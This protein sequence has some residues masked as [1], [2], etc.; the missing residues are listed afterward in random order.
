MRDEA[1]M[2]R[3]TDGAPP[4]RTTLAACAG[5]WLAVAA[6]AVGMASDD[7][8]HPDRWPQARST[9]LMDAATEARVTALLEQMTL[10]E[11]VGQIIQTDIGVI[12]PDELRRYPLGSVLAGADSGVHG[13]KRAPATEWLKLAREFRAVSMEARAGHVSIPV[14]FGIDA[15]HGHND[16][17]G[18]VLFPH[19]IGL[20]AAHDPDLVR[21]IGAATAEEVAAT[22]IDWTFAPTLATPRDVRWGRTYEGY[23]QDPATVRS[24]AA[25]I[26]EGLQGPASLANRIQAGHVAATAKHFLADGGTLY[27]EDEGDAVIGEDELIHIH[28]QGYPAAIATGVMTVMASYS[29]WAGNKMHSHRPLLTTI[30]KQRFGFDGFVVGDWN[31]HSQ[32]PGCNKDGCPAAINAGLDM[33]M[34]PLT[35][36]VLYRNTLAQARAHEI[37]AARLDDAVRRILRVKLKLGL[38]DAVRPFEGR[39]DLIGSPAHRAIARQAVRESLVLLKNDGVL[40]IRASARVLVA[41]RHSWDIGLQ[42]GGWTITW[43]G[44]GTTRKDVPNGET[45]HDGIKAAV[46]AAGGSVVDDSD[47]LAAARPDVAIVV[48]GE[49]P[50]AE[51]FGD[52]KLPFFQDRSA[53]RDLAHFRRLGIP[54]VSIFLSGRPLWTN[55]E[56]NLSNAFV[57]AWLPGSE[58]GGVADVLI[59]DS[60]G[61]PRVD[62]HG[63]LPYPWPRAAT[64]PPY[65]RD[66]GAKDALFPVGY[67]LSYA[68]GGSVGKLSERLSGQ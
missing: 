56:I 8:V 14:I 35:W 9:G 60:T 31:G 45:I 1:D 33:F 36:K 41:G 18:A 44:V 52:I 43:Q 46:E 27:G 4:R 67:G 66:D 32:V 5:A 15:V 2:P 29:S 10:E 7:T 26:V 12:E 37:E 34:A 25:A 58:G 42:S 62:F 24:Y 50:Y 17:V 19:N 3:G 63:T 57:A 54:V 64:L 47:D 59:G 40:P 20:G 6:P 49:T 38:F 21:R 13:D 22:G 39:M 51:M 61:R 28:A 65:A 53:L 11:K 16:I 30:L 68:H 23:A 55:P 48:F